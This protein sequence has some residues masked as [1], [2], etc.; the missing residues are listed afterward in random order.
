MI[1]S[2]KISIQTLKCDVQEIH[3]KSALET[4]ACYRCK[5]ISRGVGVGDFSF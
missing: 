1:N 4:L 5:N 2:D 3:S